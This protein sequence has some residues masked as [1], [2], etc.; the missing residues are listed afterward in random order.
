MS[1]LVIFEQIRQHHNRVR[2]HLPN[3]S[4]HVFCGYAAWTFRNIDYSEV[5]KQPMSKACNWKTEAKG[6]VKCYGASHS[7]YC[8]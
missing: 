6:S 2:L 4:P 7:M 8:H 3:H 1:Y 5:D